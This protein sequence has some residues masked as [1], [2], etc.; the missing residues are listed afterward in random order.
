MIALMKRLFVALV[1]FAL[2]TGAFAQ[3]ESVPLSEEVQAL[4]GLLGE[5]EGVMKMTIPGTSDPIDLKSTVSVK[6]YGPY[7]ETIYTMEMPGAPKFT[8]HQFL[9]YD[10]ANKTYRSW[11]FDDNTNEPRE[12]SGTWDGKKLVMTS[13]PHGGTVTRTTFQPKG[14]NEISFLLEMKQGE[15]FVKLGDCIFKRKA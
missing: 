11:G 5:W 10:S 15:E 9:T 1:T 12:E 13:K 8:G 3:A 2:C 6:L 4:S 14:K 7:Q